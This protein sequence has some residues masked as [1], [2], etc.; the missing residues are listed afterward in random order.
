MMI[1]HIKLLHYLIL[2]KDKRLKAFIVIKN[3]Q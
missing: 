2:N 3:I 1:F